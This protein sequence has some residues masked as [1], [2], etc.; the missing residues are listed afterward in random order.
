VLYLADL[1]TEPTQAR[2]RA[3]EPVT[4]IIVREDLHELGAK[5]LIIGE[6]W[7]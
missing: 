2:I 7:S 5:R 4:K 6:E 3:I 1:T